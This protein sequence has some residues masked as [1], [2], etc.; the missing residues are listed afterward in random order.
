MFCA[1]INE[2]TA[3]TPKRRPSLPPRC[4]GETFGGPKAR[5][6][7]WQPA[8]AIVPDSDNDLSKNS[9]RPISVIA[10]AEGTFSKVLA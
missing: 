5:A 7:S 4:T 6:G 8:H 9:A 2:G 10:A 3:R 1:Y